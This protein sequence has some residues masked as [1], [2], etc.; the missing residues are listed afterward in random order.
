[1][2]FLIGIAIVLIIVAVFPISN[3]L[4]SS[5]KEE[6]PYDPSLF[7]DFNGNEREPDDHIDE[8]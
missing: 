1:M 7:N 4:S 3:R 5:D 6:E 2:G 8:E